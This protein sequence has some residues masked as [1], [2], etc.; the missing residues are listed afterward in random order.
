MSVRNI[1]IF[2]SGAGS[3]AREIIRYVE[4]HVHLRVACVA[5]NRPGA[6]VLDVAAAAGIPVI[7]LERQRFFYEDGHFPDFEPLRIDLVVLAGFL[8]KLPHILIHAYPERILNIHPALLP[9]YGGKGMYGM[10]VHTAVVRAGERQSGITI[11]LVD[12]Q[13]DHGKTLFQ[14]GLDVQPWDT[15]EDLAARIHDLEH[16]HFARVIDAYL[17][18]KTPC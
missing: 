4:H 7:A 18:I 12:E 14:A 9:A 6:G 10:H 13:Y 15:A 5:C 11:H 8:W 16:K 17:E 2:A 1:A 3:N